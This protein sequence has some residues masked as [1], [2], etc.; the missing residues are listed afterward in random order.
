MFKVKLV[1]LASYFGREDMSIPKIAEF[2]YDGLEVYPKYAGN[3]AKLGITTEELINLCSQYN[4]T[5]EASPLGGVHLVSD[6]Q[7]KRK[8]AL[9]NFKLNLKWLSEVGGKIAQCVPAW[10][11][12]RFRGYKEAVKT[13]VIEVLRK[14]GKEAQDYGVV[15]G[16]E[17]CNRF[18]M[19]YMNTL[20]DA[21]SVV[22][23]IG[24]ESVKVAG[25]T[26]HMHIEEPD[27][28]RAI[29][30]AKDYLVYMH[31]SDNARL[32]PGLGSMNLKAI[33]NALADIGYRGALSHFEVK[34]YPDAETAARISFN[35]TRAL[36]DIS[37]TLR[38]LKGR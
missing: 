11:Y 38:T 35:Y 24:L 5:V 34:P 22:K 33:V 6:D 30:E 29:Y 14:L 10:G 32:A 25:D 20:Q 18:E 19:S 3:R 8:A 28:V 37:E 7:T 2:G 13:R 16:I 15:I 12:T 17:P 9:K 36:L 26:Y 27:P 23:E 31:F 21:I 1:T 4:L